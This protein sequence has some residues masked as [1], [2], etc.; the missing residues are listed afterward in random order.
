MN[1]LTTYAGLDIH[2]QPKGSNQTIKTSKLEAA[3]ST[4]SSLLVFRY[5]SF[6]EMRPEEKIMT[7]D[8]FQK[9]VLDRLEKLDKLDADVQ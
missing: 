4:A 2:L 9:Q 8:D 1:C 5:N 3:Q 6:K 7:Q